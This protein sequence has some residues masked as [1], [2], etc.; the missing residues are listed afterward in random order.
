MI[1]AVEL[2]RMT[3]TERTA[4]FEAGIVWDLNDAPEALVARAREWAQ[5]RIALETHKPA[6]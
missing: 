6:E 4:V 2:E 1:T 3:P 5:E